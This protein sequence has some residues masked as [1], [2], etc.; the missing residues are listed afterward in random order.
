[1]KKQVSGPREV[2]PEAPDR[3][4][5]NKTDTIELNPR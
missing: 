4:G 3:A 1:M 2:P 5:D